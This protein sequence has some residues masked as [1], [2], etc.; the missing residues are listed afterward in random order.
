MDWPY[1]VNWQSIDPHAHQSLFDVALHETIKYESIAHKEGAIV[2]MDPKDNARNEDLEWENRVLCSDESCIGTIGPDGRCRECG[3]PYEGELPPGIGAV[4][5]APQDPPDDDGD[6]V[7]DDNEA[8]SE[9]DG[10]DLSVG[11]DEWARRTLCRDES[12]IGVI[13]EDGRCKECGKPY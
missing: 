13:G 5:D 4:S 11:D 3:L 12:C 10:D 2:I 6:A 8:E 9:E 7:D 1:P